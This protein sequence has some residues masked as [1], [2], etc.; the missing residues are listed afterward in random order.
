M[1]N[2]ARSVALA[3]ILASGLLLGTGCHIENWECDSRVLCDEHGCVQC[4]E[5]ECDPLY[6]YDDYDCPEGYYCSGSDECKAKDDGWNWEPDPPPPPGP[7]EC[8]TDFDCAWGIIC[9]DGLCVPEE[10]P[11]DNPPD[12]DSPVDEPCPT[13]CEEPPVPDPAGCVYN[14]ECGDAG[15]CVNGECLFA[16]DSD[17]DCG[18]GEICLTGLC[19]PAPSCQAKADCPDGYQCVNGLCDVFALPDTESPPAEDPCQ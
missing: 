6:C 15:L 12:D 2:R 11:V 8:V 14:I 17:A 9:I 13:Q 19:L 18:D 16:C 4:D 7:T 10:P 3:T 5:F 1:R